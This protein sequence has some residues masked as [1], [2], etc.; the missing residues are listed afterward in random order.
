MTA[1]G[2]FGPPPSQEGGGNYLREIVQKGTQSV[3]SSGSSTCCKLPSR[4]APGSGIGRQEGL[5][6]ET[7]RARAPLREGSKPSRDGQ[8]AGMAPSRRGARK[9]PGRLYRE[10]RLREFAPR[11]G[12]TASPWV[13]GNKVYC[14]NE[15]GE[16]YVVQAGPEFKLLATNNLDEMCMATPAVVRGNLLIRTQTK[17]YRIGQAE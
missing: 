11:A 16:T 17:L 14:L 7:S 5:P 1:T 6:R 9:V 3:S 13:C 4:P 8:R 12:F 10:G 15:D 2:V